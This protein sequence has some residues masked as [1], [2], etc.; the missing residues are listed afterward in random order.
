MVDLVL[1]N[2]TASRTWGPAF[3]RRV[4]T[5]CEP[6]LKLPRR[7]TGEL[8]IVLVGRSEIRRL[9]RTW[10]HK[11]KPTDVLSFALTTRPIAGYTAVSLGDLFIC[12]AVVRE[13]AKAAGTG[14]RVQMTWTVVHGLLHLAGYD[15]ERSTAAAARMAALERKILQRL[16]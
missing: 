16:S 2:R 8:G 4:V 15:H 6:H 13:K 14:V 11:D 3:F 1:K 12:P 9:N 10:R 7:H 5:V